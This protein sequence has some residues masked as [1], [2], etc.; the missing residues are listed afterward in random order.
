MIFFVRCLLSSATYIYIHTRFIRSSVNPYIIYNMHI[1]IMMSLI[2]DVREFE[3]GFIFANFSSEMFIFSK[4]I[5]RQMEGKILTRNLSIFIRQYTRNQNAFIVDRRVHIPNFIIIK[6]DHGSQII[7]ELVFFKNVR[8]V[9][10]LKLLRK[11][12]S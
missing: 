5:I 6:E 9:F 4:C 8:L 2:F 1:Y 3:V 11:I 7:C 10:I 12:M